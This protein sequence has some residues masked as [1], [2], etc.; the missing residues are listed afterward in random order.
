MRFMDPPPVACARARSLEG[1]PILNR[2]SAPVEWNS[3][4]FGSVYAG[5][6]M[7]LLSTSTKPR[8]VTHCFAENEDRM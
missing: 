3:R 1:E 2:F 6:A 7:Y 8:L 4:S 5:W